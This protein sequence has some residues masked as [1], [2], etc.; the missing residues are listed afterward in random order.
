MATISIVISYYNSHSTCGRLLDRLQKTFQKLPG[1]NFEIV[2]VDDGSVDFEIETVEKF[3][4]R[5]NYPV[6]VIRF[7]QNYGQTA[8]ILAGLKNAKGNAAVI[9]SSDLQDPPELIYEMIR[10]WKAGFEVVAGARIQRNDGL[11]RNLGAKLWYEFVR[12]R[13]HPGFPK[14]GSDYCLISEQISASLVQDPSPI[15]YLQV[16]IL[17]LAQKISY[18]DY[19][20]G[21]NQKER[22]SSWSF[23]KLLRYV[24]EIAF[25]YADLRIFFFKIHFLLLIGIFTAI[26]LPK[27]SKLW[28]WI[29]IALFTGL[30]LITDW[31]YL[32]VKKRQKN[33]DPNFKLYTIKQVFNLGKDCP[34]Q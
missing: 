32:R 12:K 3:A 17:K 30:V 23:F 33:K 25:V 4:S 16:D 9:L 26:L 22:Q 13:I 18:I 28:M 29:S 1:F 5:S 19:I 6:K 24:S 15:R 8:S 21:E 27:D 31:M 7:D 20:R 10:Q 2:L 14:N 34:S 11:F